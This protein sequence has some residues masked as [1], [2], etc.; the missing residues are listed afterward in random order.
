MFPCTHT[1]NSRSICKLEIVKNL[2]TES[3][4]IHRLTPAFTLISNLYKL[5][6]G[7]QKILFLWKI[8][9]NEDSKLV[10]K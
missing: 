2:K 5:V 3:L 10:E 7:Q 4:C 9:K 1:K 8:N 6:F